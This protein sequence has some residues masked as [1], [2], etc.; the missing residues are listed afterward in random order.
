MEQVVL[1]E[2]NGCKFYV[3]FVRVVPLGFWFRIHTIDGTHNV[4]IDYEGTVEQAETEVIQSF[5]KYL[6]D[7]SYLKK[8]V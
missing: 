1:Q 5:K 4:T 3:E 8:S 2:Y 6:Y 7:H